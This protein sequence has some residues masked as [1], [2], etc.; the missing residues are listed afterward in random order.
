MSKS[1]E[2]EDNHLK[3][4]SILKN[5]SFN[6]TAASRRSKASNHRNTRHSTSVDRQFRDLKTNG[7]TYDVTDTKLHDSKIRT[8]KMVKTADKDIMLMNP[9]KKRR[10][11]ANLN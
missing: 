9:Q 7:K 4:M 5:G 2:T 6:N 8:K 11:T 10:T 3:V 1:K